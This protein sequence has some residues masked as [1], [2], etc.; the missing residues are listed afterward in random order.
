[1]LQSMEWK[2]NGLGERRPS[3]SRGTDLFRKLSQRRDSSLSPQLHQCYSTSTFQVWRASQITSGKPAGWQAALQT[4]ALPVHLDIRKV[5]FYSKIKLL[6]ICV[7]RDGLYIFWGS[8]STFSIL[9]CDI[10][11]TSICWPILL[12]RF[13]QKGNLGKTTKNLRIVASVTKVS[14][15]WLS[16]KIQ[17]WMSHWVKNFPYRQMID[18]SVLAILKVLFQVVLILIS[19]MTF[20]QFR[21]LHLLISS[22]RGQETSPSLL[23]NAEN[24]S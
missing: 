9:F 3:L 10:T 24:N 2:R 14:N 22:K 5:L 23:E 1:M 11:V 4:N 21:L 7:L 13:C 8:C 12:D 15:V 17:S 16:G 6:W 20:C 18:I 19:Q